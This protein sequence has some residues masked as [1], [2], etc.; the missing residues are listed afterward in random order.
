MSRRSSTASDEGGGRG[1]AHP[2]PRRLLGH[3]GQHAARRVARSRPPEARARSRPRRSRRALP[4]RRA[5]R[6]SRS[7][8]RQLRRGASAAAATAVARACT[9]TAA[10]CTLTQSRRRASPS[11]MGA[12]SA[13]RSRAFVREIRRLISRAKLVPVVRD[14]ALAIFE[15]LAAAEAQ[16]CTASTPTTCTSTKSA[17][18]D[19]IVDVTGVAIGLHRLGIERITCTPLPLGPRHG[20]LRSRPAAAAGARDAR[21]AARRARSCRRAST[22]KP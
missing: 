5:A 19:A 12:T 13:G 1:T 16:A 20:A 17:R 4:A 6:A 10:S 11:V 8:R 15:A 9:A 2:A 22:G 21:A 3:R 14:R 7:A 18:V